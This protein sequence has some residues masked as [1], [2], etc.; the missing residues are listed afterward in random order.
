MTGWQVAE[1]APRDGTI[2]VF[3]ERHPATYALTPPMIG[4]YQDGELQCY[5]GSRWR[6]WSGEMETWAKIPPV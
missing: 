5:T 3:R 4:R 1:T 2:F 6:V